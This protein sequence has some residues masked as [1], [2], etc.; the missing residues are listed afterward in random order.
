MGVDLFDKPLAVARQRVA[1]SGLDNF[2]VVKGDALDLPAEM[3]GRYD[4]A[5]IIDS[6]H[7]LPDPYKAL[8]AVHKVLTPGGYF[9]IF[10]T[11]TST[12]VE[13]NTG[14]L[15]V[16]MLYTWSIYNCM[17]SSMTEEPRVGYG[18]CWGRKNIEEAIKRNFELEKVFDLPCHYCLYVCKK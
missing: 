11:G 1:S 15:D 4:M 8:A 13:E 10:D 17:A 16:A 5:I 7:D 12:K 9:V 3:E 14:D 18:T 6:L 2:S